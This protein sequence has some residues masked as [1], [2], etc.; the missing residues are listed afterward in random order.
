[1]GMGLHWVNKVQSLNK[2]PVV[3][4]VLRVN[5]EDSYDLNQLIQ[6]QRDADLCQHI[7]ELSLVDKA[8][9][10]TVIETKFI[11]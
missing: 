3:D 8:T 4:L 6:C 2:L 9:S 5:G 11:E 10:F 1:M 7:F